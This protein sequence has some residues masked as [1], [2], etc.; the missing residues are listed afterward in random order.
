MTDQ[1]QVNL[2]QPKLTIGFRVDM[3]LRSFSG[4]FL[5]TNS[6]PL[7][8]MKPN[9]ILCD[10]PCVLCPCF[11]QVANDCWKFLFCW[12]VTGVPILVDSTTLALGV[13]WPEIDPTMTLGA[14]AGVAGV[15]VGVAATTPGFWSRRFCD[16]T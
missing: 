9:S 16:G 12:N 4:R 5:L 6:A 13:P 10:I 2:F 11:T 3:F 15:P 1:R 8:I 7:F 14:V